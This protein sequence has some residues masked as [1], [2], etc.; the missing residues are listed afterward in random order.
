M[1]KLKQYLEQHK[2]EMDVDHPP[3]SVWQNIQAKSS[4]QNVVKRLPL[5]MRYAAAVLFI[6]IGA[7]VWVMTTK[8]SQPQ[9]AQE[10]G[11]QAQDKS[12]LVLQKKGN[13]KQ[14]IATE[15]IV[16]VKSQKIPVSKRSR[17]NK[18]K[19]I[20]ND[21]AAVNKG[22]ANLIAYQLQR[23]RT[24]P[25]YAESPGYF[26]EFVA[27]LKQMK[28]DEQVVQADM[29]RYGMNDQL[30]ESLINIYQ[31]KLNLLKSLQKEIKQMNS[32]IDGK[33]NAAGMHPYYLNL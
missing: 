23:L 21:V 30:V 2:D 25:V 31:Q 1:D 22:Y 16:S 12:E 15:E 6:I 18:S 33:S 19:T 7:T 24:T 29:Q 4:H 11:K 27:Q 17:S 14:V 5:F 3:V 13:E 10:K 20:I 28:K 9:V 26:T 32:A 8:R